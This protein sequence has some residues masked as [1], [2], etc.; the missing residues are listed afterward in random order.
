MRSSY[1]SIELL[2]AELVQRVVLHLSWKGQM[3]YWKIRA[4]KRCLHWFVHTQECVAITHVFAYMHIHIYVCVIACAQYC[5]FVLVYALMCVHVC[6][7]VCM[8]VMCICVHV[9]MCVHA[10]RHVY[11]H[12]NFSFV[13][14]SAGSI[15]RDLRSVISSSF[16]IS[17]LGRTP[18]KSLVCLVSSARGFPSKTSEVGE[19]QPRSVFRCGRSC[20]CVCVCA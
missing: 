9:C 17:R 3:L 19:K 14:W 2:P 16:K 20:V 8:C 1:S 12:L 6:V 18:C 10:P 7:H 5:V 11:L 13:S 4:S 15:H